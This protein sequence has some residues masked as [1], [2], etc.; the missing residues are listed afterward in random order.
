MQAGVVAWINFSVI[1]YLGIPILEK[2]I[3]NFGIN[4]IK[5]AIPLRKDMR[6]RINNSL[7]WLPIGKNFNNLKAG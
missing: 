5:Y 3:N 7:V 4:K 1:I 2:F 6:I